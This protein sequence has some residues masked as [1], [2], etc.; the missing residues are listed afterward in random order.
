M[1]FHR[2]A[3]EIRGC[4]TV[5]P[6]KAGGELDGPQVDWELRA[7][8]LGNPSQQVDRGAEN[9]FRQ[10]V[11]Q[12]RRAHAL[13]QQARDETGTNVAR[14]IRLSADAGSAPSGGE[15]QARDL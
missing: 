6:S 3:K 11:A 13:R 4:G 9:R 10:L 7:W 12:I 1:G 5:K 8:N 15:D 2:T 14:F